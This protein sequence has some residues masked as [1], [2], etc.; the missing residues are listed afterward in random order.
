MGE[1]GQARLINIYI[2]GKKYKVPETLT[3]LKAIEFAGY[4]FIR[5]C[6][7][8]GGICGACATVYRTAGDYRLKS[9]LACQ[10]VVEPEMYLTQI[11]FYPAN[12]ST[13]DI[14]ELEPDA[15]SLIEHYPELLRCMGCNA[16]SKVCPQDLE[17][18]EYMSAAMKGELERVAELSFECLMCGLCASRCPG[19]NVQYNIGILARRLYARHLRPEAPDLEQRVEEI[20]H[21]KYEDDLE[22][23]IKASEEVLRRRY[24]ETQA[25]RE[26][27]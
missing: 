7:C 15:A 3:I 14:E 13:Y 20:E 6:G 21:G 11:P 22:V 9:G 12:K 24:D 2:M 10:T 26:P 5:G 16:C 18:M 25:D 19:E 17:T 27:D 1:E 4:Q 23:L 8:R